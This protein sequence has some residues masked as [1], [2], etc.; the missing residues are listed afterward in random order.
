MQVWLSRGNPQEESTHVQ[1]TH[2]TSDSQG[3][4]PA[5]SL[6]KPRMSPQTPKDHSQHPHSTSQNKPHPC[7][8]IWQVGFIPLLVPR[9]IIMR[10][11]CPNAKSQLNKRFADIH[12]SRPTDSTPYHPHHIKEMQDKNTRYHAQTQA[13]R[14]K[15]SSTKCWQGLRTAGALIYSKRK[16]KVI[17]TLCKHFQKHEGCGRTLLTHFMK[18]VPSSHQR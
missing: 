13:K 16:S 14:F 1:A 9:V 4:Q 15:N 5:P 11:L 17:P 6:H 3:P 2:V 8:S 10:I 7:L 12:H 18:P